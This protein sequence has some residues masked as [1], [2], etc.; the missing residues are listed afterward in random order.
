MSCKENVLY[1]INLKNCGETKMARWPPYV[2]GQTI[3]KLII[4]FRIVGLADLL[5][6]G[7]PWDFL[8]RPT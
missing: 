8:V 5:F 2:Q 7:L 6:W 3:N 4:F 1:I